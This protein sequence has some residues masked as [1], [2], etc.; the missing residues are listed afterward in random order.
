MTGLSMPKATRTHDEKRHALTPGPG[1]QH[2]P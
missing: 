1:I 2:R